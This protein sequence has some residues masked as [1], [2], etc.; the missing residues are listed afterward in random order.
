M[1]APSKTQSR[2][3]SHGNS[4][5]AED[6]AYKPVRQMLGYICA[7][8]VAIT[9][10]S[11]VVTSLIGIFKAAAFSDFLKGTLIPLIKEFSGDNF[12]TEALS[13]ADKILWFAI[14]TF[15]FFAVE[16]YFYVMILVYPGY[17]GGNPEFYK[18]WPLMVS[19]TL[20]TLSWGVFHPVLIL[21][22]LIPGLVSFAARYYAYFGHDSSPSGNCCLFCLCLKPWV[23]K[24][25]EDSEAPFTQ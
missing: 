4:N 19:S 16:L 25:I 3:N 2:I 23:Y 8:F 10:A 20:F 17:C 13:V 24:K 1:T 14:A 7:L 22:A 5:P 6:P 11:S 15:L 9:H 21:V 18:A 12:V